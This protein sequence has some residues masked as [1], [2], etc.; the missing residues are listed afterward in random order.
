MADERPEVKDLEEAPEPEVH[1][2]EAEQYGTASDDNLE[3]DITEQ[4]MTDNGDADGDA[5]DQ[6]YKLGRNPEPGDV[7]VDP[8]PEEDAPHPTEQQGPQGSD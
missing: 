2:T 4:P 6:P 8:V 5:D 1:G 3:A 7:G